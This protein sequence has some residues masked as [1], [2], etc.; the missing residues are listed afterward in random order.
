MPGAATDG[1]PEV[2]I[3]S[4]AHIRP[5]NL[6][7][8]NWSADAVLVTHEVACV[9]CPWSTLTPDVRDAVRTADRHEMS[10]EHTHSRE[11]ALAA[12]RKRRELWD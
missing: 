10:L 6:P 5:E 8:E 2:Q 4:V 9:W 11:Q 12:G 3:R 1:R 7:A